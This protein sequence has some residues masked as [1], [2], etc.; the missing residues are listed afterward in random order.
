VADQ[1][2]RLLAVDDW[3]FVE[4]EAVGE[5]IVMRMVFGRIS[6]LFGFKS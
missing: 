6:K 1:G 2:A 3:R 4:W 5:G